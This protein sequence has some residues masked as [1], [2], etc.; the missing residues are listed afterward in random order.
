MLMDTTASRKQYA[1]SILAVLL[2]GSALFIILPKLS[3]FDTSLATL[4]TASPALT[5]C[6]IVLALLPCLFGA[7]LYKLLAAK[8]LKYSSTTLIQLSGLFV[9]RI[10]P[11]GIG[12]L[13]LNMWYLRHKRHTLGQASVTVGLNNLLGLIGNL[14]LLAL[15]LLVFPSTLLNE[16]NTTLLS[17]A[18]LVVTIV[19]T[20]VLLVIAY[21]MRIQLHTFIQQMQTE[22]S[23]LTVRF[24]KRPQELPK[25]IVVSCLLT[26]S[27]AGCLWVCCLAIDIS[28]HFVAA[29]LILSFAVLIG[30]AVPTPGGLGGVEAVLVAGLISQSVSASNAL[31]AALLFRLV[32]YWLGLMLGLVA[33]IA[34]KRRLDASTL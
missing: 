16:L 4:G 26:L 21:I 8:P 30:T 12:G 28:I 34:V 13:S 24:L 18:V 3:S 14:G 19:M 17:P 7:W 23:R 6:A 20:F 31:A 10:L 1:L 29:F 9:N 15:A 2:I 11:A 27:N 22:F 5:F 25:A 33:L 32:T